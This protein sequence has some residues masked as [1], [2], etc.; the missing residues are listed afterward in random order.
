MRVEIIRN[1]VIAEPV[2]QSVGETIWLDGTYILE[3]N[4]V[5]RDAI[6]C[7]EQQILVSCLRISDF[8]QITYFPA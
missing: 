8:V 2:H 7:D 5:R 6:R 1:V 4:I 3:H